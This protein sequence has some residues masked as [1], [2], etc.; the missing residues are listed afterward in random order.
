MISIVKAAHRLLQEAIRLERATNPALVETD[1]ENYSDSYK[2][3]YLPIPDNGDQHYISR[4]LTKPEEFPDDCLAALLV[5]AMRSSTPIGNQVHSLCIDRVGS[6]Y[7]FC[8][9]GSISAVTL[10]QLC[11]QYQERRDQKD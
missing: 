5:E 2:L 9:S 4:A 8:I 6:S 3:L 11:E 1:E 10:Q 7:Q